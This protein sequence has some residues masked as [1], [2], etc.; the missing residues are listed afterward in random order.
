MNARS[1]GTMPLS[2]RALLSDKSLAEYLDCGLATARK[3]SREAEAIRK[4]GKTKLNDRR[5][6]DEFLKYL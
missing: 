3:I 5:A 2:E 6:I 1:K 4:F